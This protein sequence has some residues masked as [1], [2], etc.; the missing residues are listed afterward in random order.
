MP[1]PV[2]ETPDQSIA[3]RRR[4]ADVFAAF[5][6]DARRGLPDEGAATRHTRDGPPELAAAAPLPAW[7]RF[8]AQFREALVILLLTATAISA[9]LWTSGRDAALPYEA[10][11]ILT[12]VLFNATMGSARESRAEAAAVA[13][14]LAMSA[15]DAAVVRGGERRTV[16]A[17]DIVP[18]DVILIEEGDTIPAH[19][20]VEHAAHPDER[21]ERDFAFVSLLGMIDPP[22]PEAKEAVAR[23]RGAG[24]RPILITGDHPR[25]AAVRARE[26]GA[27]ASS[28]LWLGEPGRLAS[29]GRR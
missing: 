17:A 1:T 18:G 24:I 19:A 27:V 28:V 23:A 21:V 2:S 8:V 3:Y 6:S 13:A 14:L 5:G 22:R 4:A 15:A 7:R 16:P 11:A 29:L 9:G 20:L 12:V 25:T 26:P 10:M